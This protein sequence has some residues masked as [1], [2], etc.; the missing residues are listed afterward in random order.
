MIPFPV[1]IAPASFMWIISKLLTEHIQED[2]CHIFFNVIVIFAD[3]EYDSERH[4]RSV[5]EMMRAQV[6]T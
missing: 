1:M 5:L 2:Y 6:S 3:G 4:V